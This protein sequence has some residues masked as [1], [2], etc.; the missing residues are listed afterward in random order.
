M[1]GVIPAQ[2]ERTTDQLEIAPNGCITPHL[3]LCPPQSMFDL[4]VD[5]A[6]PTYVTRTI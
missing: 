3:V 6:Q 1:P 4:D 2:G 5:S